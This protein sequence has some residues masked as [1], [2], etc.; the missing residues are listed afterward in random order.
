MVGH[1][2]AQLCCGHG[3]REI[4][5][6]PQLDGFQVAVHVEASRN[7]QDGQ[8]TVDFGGAFQH[9]ASFKIP[10]SL[11]HNDEVK[12]V[13]IQTADGLG[14]GSTRPNLVAQVR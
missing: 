4:I 2:A 9:A 7:D 1:E 11:T 12:T 14:V 13:G 8:A 3:F 6:R 10:A 5:H